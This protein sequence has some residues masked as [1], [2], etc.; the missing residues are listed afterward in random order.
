MSQLQAAPLVMQSLTTSH[1]VPGCFLVN[2]K[3]P[4]V[5]FCQRHFTRRCYTWVSI[6]ASVVSECLS[7]AIYEIMRIPTLQGSPRNAPVKMSTKIADMGIY[8]AY[9][10][11]LRGSPQRKRKGDHLHA[12]LISVYVYF[13]LHK[14]RVGFTN[15]TVRVCVL[16]CKI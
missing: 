12:I 7:A 2:I 3:K 16:S 5:Q 4:N 14:F 6:M 1:Q 9:V 11:N 15:K 10:A 8:A 13:K